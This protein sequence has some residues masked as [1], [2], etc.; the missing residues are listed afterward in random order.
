MVK[1]KQPIPGYMLTTADY[2]LMLEFFKRASTLAPRLR[3][4]MRL[5]ERF[6]TTAGRAF[7]HT[8]ESGDWF[9]DLAAHG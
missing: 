8:A 5:F 9:P 1:K 2:G 7:R 3:P 6:S 4:L